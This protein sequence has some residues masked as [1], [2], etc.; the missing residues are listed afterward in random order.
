V[1]LKL[2][3]LGVAF[4]IVKDCDTWDAGSKL[5]FPA[6]LALMVQVPAVRTAT[7]VSVTVQ[8]PDVAEVNATV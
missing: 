6:W 8:T 7:V 5:T 3:R 1:L 2:E 4:A